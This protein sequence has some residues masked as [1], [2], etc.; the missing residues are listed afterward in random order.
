MVAAGSVGVLVAIFFPPD[1]DKAGAHRT[2]FAQ[3]A[4]GRIDIHRQIDG[5]SYTTFQ[6]TYFE[7]DLVYGNG[8]FIVYPDG[9]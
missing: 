6:T 9:K 8:N 2:T 3:A 1:W 7:C 4:P 5:D